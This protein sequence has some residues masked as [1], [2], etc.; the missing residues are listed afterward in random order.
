MSNDHSTHTRV[1]SCIQCGWY[2]GRWSTARRSVSCRAPCGMSFRYQHFWWYPKWTTCLAKLQHK[3]LFCSAMVILYPQQ[4]RKKKQRFIGL[5]TGSLCWHFLTQHL[6]VFR[7]HQ[8]K[9][10][11]KHYT[12]FRSKIKLS[13]N[14]LH[15]PRI[16][17]KQYS[18]NKKK[19]ELDHAYKVCQTLGNA[20]A[21]CT[22]DRKSVV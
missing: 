2:G 3:H 6:T 8:Q 4:F 15:R 16:Q 1:K 13:W 9:I 19:S 12:A 21:K 14:H 18:K 22:W 20:G 7:W 17:I 11:T 5:H 10:R